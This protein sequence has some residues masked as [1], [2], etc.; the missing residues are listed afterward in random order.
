MLHR[1]AIAF[2]LILWTG[3]AQAKTLY[4]NG[5]TGSDATTYAN[6][7][8][9]APWLTLGRAV[10]GNANR[11]T[12]NTG[13]A[14]AA[15]DIVVIA[16]GTYHTTETTG[17][18]YDPVYN[19][20][21]EGAWNSGTNVC[22]STITFQAATQYG[23]TLT[24]PT[25]GDANPVIGTY[26]K[27]CIIWD[28]FSI[29]EANAETPN[30]GGQ[31]SLWSSDGSQLINNDFQAMIPIR[32]PQDFKVVVGS[33]S[34]GGYPNRSDLTLLSPEWQRLHFKL[35]LERMGRRSFRYIVKFDR[36]FRFL[37]VHFG[38]PN[39]NGCRMKR[40]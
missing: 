7:T 3:V 6:N 18:R 19:P 21:N 28:G 23:V 14:A 2:I 37:G 35:T 12:P 10:W 24:T 13:E 36:I 25:G 39:L 34:Y 15:G 4:V 29:D 33:E 38:F 27:D 30:D 20:V 5:G 11:G 17:L 40:P 16:D 9:I 8:A 22:D 1:L 31:A 26:L 32:P